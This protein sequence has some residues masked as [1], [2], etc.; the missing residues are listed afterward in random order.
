[1]ISGIKK[2]SDFVAYLRTIVEKDDSG[3]AN[4]SSLKRIAYVNVSNDLFGFTSD[5]CYFAYVI[6][7]G[8][9]AGLTKLMKL[10]NGYYGIN[11][12]SVLPEYRGKSYA[13]NMIE[14][15]VKWAKE[16]N[17]VLTPS[18]YTKVGYI[19]LKPLL[20]KYCAQ[21]GVKLI[22][23]PEDDDKHGWFDMN[24]PSRYDTIENDYQ[25]LKKRTKKF[26]ESLR[27]TSN[28]DFIS[29]VLEGIDIIFESKRPESWRERNVLG[30]WSRYRG[31]KTAED[32]MN[33]AFFIT[34]KHQPLQFSDVESLSDA[35]IQHAISYGRTMKKKVPSDQKPEFTDKQMKEYYKYLSKE[36][37][38]FDLEWEMEKERLMSAG[39]MDE[40]GNI[41]PPDERY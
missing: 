35:G 29:A 38:K 23:K 4:W 32:R 19:Q 3:K 26:V 20:E 9:V 39:I 37:E 24:V 10:T 14:T 8:V 40:E 25:E 12:I 34:G 28:T 1:M 15:I 5:R 18:S 16:N 13:T 27:S 21:Y 36:Q 30:I 6:E 41:I 2:T 31:L 17:E 7:D 11:Y 33:Y 22:A